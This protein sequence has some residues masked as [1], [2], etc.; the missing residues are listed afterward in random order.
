M[1]IRLRGHREGWRFA[2]GMF[3]TIHPNIATFCLLVGTAWHFGFSGPTSRH[4]AF[5]LCFG[6]LSIGGA[7]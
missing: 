2:F 1:R 5:G 6:P 4:T 7:W 3:V